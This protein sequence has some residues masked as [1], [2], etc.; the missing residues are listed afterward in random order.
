MAILSQFVNVYGLERDQP[1]PPSNLTPT[2]PAGR[3]AF[4][5]F[6]FFFLGGERD[7]ANPKRRIPSRSHALVLTLTSHRLLSATENA[8]PFYLDVCRGRELGLLE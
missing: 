6:L 5:V 8:R 4:K 2:H 3:I 7:P 1:L